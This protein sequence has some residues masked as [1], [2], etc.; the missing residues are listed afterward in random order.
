MGNAI[1]RSEAFIALITTKFLTDEKCKEQC[2]TALK[3]NKPMYAI[4]CC[5][6]SPELEK[7]LAEFETGWRKTFDLWE[8]HRINKPIK[9][10]TILKEI[11]KDLQIIRAVKDA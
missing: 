3:L 2:Q 8:S 11:K 10:D 5:K 9:V 1:N 6:Q 4:I 7:L